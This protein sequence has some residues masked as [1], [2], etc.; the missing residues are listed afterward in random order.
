MIKQIAS[1]I[2]VMALVGCASVKQ[3]PAPVMKGEITPVNVMEHDMHKDMGMNN[4]MSMPH[5]MIKGKMLTMAQL[6]QL[7]KLQSMNKSV[8]FDFDKST[9]KPEY[10]PVLEEHA[11]FIKETNADVMV[12]GNTDEKGSREYNVALGHRRAESVK[13]SLVVI[14]VNA[15]NVEAT[16]LGEE[17]T[18]GLGDDKDRRADF[19]YQTE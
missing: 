2:L 6:E 5:V 8:Y 3:E 14:G 7:A 9:I 17:K 15:N 11:K 12:Q 4:G 13:E 1:G 19:V 10:F 16:S 18:T